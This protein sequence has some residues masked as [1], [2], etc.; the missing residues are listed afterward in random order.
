MKSSPY[1]VAVFA[2]VSA[3]FLSALT[4]SAQFQNIYGTGAKTT[5]F[6]K[7]IP[8]GA[9]FY[10][11]GAVGGLA[12]VSRINSAGVCQWTHS[13][14]ISSGWE[15]AVVVPGSG[16]LIMVG[17][18]GSRDRSI[19]G[20]LTRTG[21]EVCIT[22]LDEPGLEGLFRIDQNPGSNTYSVI[23]F[24][25]TPSTLRDVVIYNIS[26]NCVINSKKQ[27]FSTVDDDFYLN[28]EVMANG[29]ITVAG[30]QG[31][32]A[33]IF[34]MNSTGNFVAGVQGP[35]QFSY[36]DLARTGNGDLLAIAN[37]QT[38]SPP[39]VMRF[40]A[41]LLPVWEISVNGLFSLD[42]VLDGGNGEIYVMG[43]TNIGGTCCQPVV[44]KLDDSNGPPTTPVWTKYLTNLGNFASF[45][46]LT[47]GGQIATADA[48]FG[49]PNNFGP[50]DGVLLL[51]DR[52][53]NSDCTVDFDVTLT[54]EN[55][56]F[57]GP[58]PLELFAAEMPVKTP[59][60]GSMVALSQASVC[61]TDPCE[62]SF[63]VNYLDN[64]GHVEI[65]STSTGPQPIG[66][67]WCSGENTPNLDLQLPCGPY[68]YCVTITCADGSMSTVTQTIQVSE[69]IPPQAV[70][71]PGF[72]VILGPDCT[73]T[74]TPVMIDGGSTDNCRIE[75]MSVSPGV[76]TGC[77]NFPVTLSV[78]DWC[79]NVGACTTS[80]QTI[81][82]VP[83]V[84]MCPP[85]V[86]KNC[87]TDT[88]PNFTGMATA[89]DNC[90]SVPVITYADLTLG[91]LPCDGIIQRT[92]TATDSCGNEASCVQNIVVTDIDPPMINC[93][94]DLT[95]G[96]DPGQCFYTGTIPLPTAT[97]NCNPNP[98]VTCYLVT[99]SGLVPITTQTKFPKGDNTICC[100]ADDGCVDVG[101]LL[102]EA[103]CEANRWAEPG[104]EPGEGPENIL[105]TLDVQPGIPPQTLVQEGLIGGDCF[106]VSNVT[107][108]GEPSQLG[109]FTN[110]ISN[111]GFPSGVILATGPAILAIGP[112]DSDS[113]GIPMG[114]NNTPDPDLATLTTGTQYDIAVLEFD[115]IPT[116]GILSLNYV[117][118]SEEY[119]ELA[120]SAL[121]DVFGIFLSGPGIPGGKQ[122]IA[123]VPATTLPTGIGTVNHITNNGFYVNNQPAGSNNLCGQLPV[124]GPAVNELQYDGYTRKFTAVANVIP[125]Q[126]YHIKIAIADVGDGLNDSAVFLNGGSF[127]AGGI[128]SVAWVVNSDPNLQTI[129]EDCG[130]VEL[131]FDRLDQ[132]ITPLTVAFAVGGTATP[133]VDYVALP[134]SVTI[135]AG[136][137][138]LVLPVTILNEGV[139]EGDET[140]EITL[141]NPCSAV[142][143][144]ETLTIRDFLHTQA[145]CTFT[146]TVEDQ[147]PPMITCPPGVTVYAGLDS[148]GTCSTVLSDLI[149][150]FSDNCTMVMMDYV[151]SGATTAAG[152]NFIDSTA[153]AEGTSTV[154][155]TVTDMGGNTDTCTFMVTVVCLDEQAENCCLEWAGQFGGP[156]SDGGNVVTADAA[157]NVWIAG[158]F[159]GT[160]DFDPGPV[161]YNLTAQAGRDAFIVK[162]SPA[163]TFLWSLQ[164]KGSGFDA[165]NDLIL[166]PSGNLYI[167]GTFQGVADF[168]P[169]VNTYNLT[170]QGSADIFVL[171]LDPSGGFLWAFGI[172]STA[173]DVSSAIAL[174]AGGDLI[175]TGHFFGPL[176]FDPG[177]GVAG[178]VPIGSSD[179]FIANFSPSGAFNWV[180]QIGGPSLDASADL[181]TDLAGNILVTGSFTGTV[182][183]DPGPG[184]FNLSSG[185]VGSDDIFVTKFDGAGNFLWA[186]T[187]SRTSGPGSN[188]VNSIAVDGSG[189]VFTT[190]LLFGPTDFD[191]GPGTAVL[192]PVSPS[193]AD[194]FVS[195][196]SSTGAYEWAKR[197]GGSSGEGGESITTDSKGNVYTSGG[198]SGTFDFDPGP[199]VSVL[200]SPGGAST[201]IQKLT[202]AGDFIWAKPFGGLSSQS[203]GL[204]LFVAADESVYCSGT[205]SGSGDFDPGAKTYTLTAAGPYDAYLFKLSVCSKLDTCYC[206]AF[207]DMF[208]RGPQGAMSRPVLCGGPPLNIGCP[209]P[210]IGF[211]LTGS[212]MC[213]GDSCTSSADLDWSLYGPDNSL[214][215]SDTASAAPWF[216]FNLPSSAF[217]QSGVYTL[218]LSGHCGADSCPCNIQFMVEEGCMETCPCDIADLISDVNQGFATAYAAN[219]CRVCFTPLALSD[220]DEVEWFVD[221]P[222]GTAV[223]TSTGNQTFCH[224]FPTGGTYT[225][226]MTV[227]RKRADGSLCESS[228]KNQTVTVTCLTRTVCETSLFPNPDFDEGAVAGS[229]GMEGMSAGWTRA[230]GDPH[231]D[232]NGGKKKVR[233]A[234][235]FDNADV[236]S[237]QEAICLQKTTGTISLRHG[238]KVNGIRSTLN[239]QFFTG[240]DYTFGAC[241]SENCFQVARIEL[242]PSDTSEEFDVVIP[243]DISGWAPAELCGNGSGVMIRPAIFVTND[244][245]DEQ[246]V[247]TRSVIDLDYFCLD[248]ILVG[249]NGPGK[250]RSMRLYPNPSA[251]S[252][253]LELAQAASP[254][255]TIRIIGL[256][257]QVVNEQR[258]EI[259]RMQQRVEAGN[260]PAGLY[261]IQLSIEGRTVGVLKWVKQ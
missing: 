52:D 129:Y 195:K 10:V 77:G 182:D 133:G 236:L 249:V 247:D 23:G 132:A 194:I 58:Q 163:G 211:T 25:N 179:L 1:Y 176:D 131:V 237:T 22:F 168:D 108:R 24:H 127:D 232:V 43:R 238:I 9:D 251:G 137:D 224:T 186:N 240:D 122:N 188:H 8:D 46:S 218:I 119:C 174:G 17:A 48:L 175:L 92:W 255:T 63:T 256:T 201:F 71:L 187:F 20:E 97:D 258:V 143:P 184:V 109:A 80:V 3:L 243:Y 212:F 32:N 72:G 110:G 89:T 177:P 56:P 189:N 125:G 142:T 69:N 94:A 134:S 112:N 193:A 118:A 70:C 204:N 93:P 222:L 91:S 140:I 153:F 100:I 233:L 254:A 205:F 98:T 245:G 5:I 54:P 154:I 157:G 203:S 180:R 124:S 105:T 53:L 13:L 183:F 64:C 228:V 235:N 146:L 215:A 248:G 96:T 170:S 162:L 27:F 192:T 101:P 85:N 260:L 44:V 103:P 206:G 198:F 216:G 246:G 135:P 88:S 40:D 37:T 95:V 33:V 15:D 196:L 34:R 261:F 78:T 220:C 138:K 19:I 42:Q 213:A 104:G 147:E 123:V 39:R 209:A 210:G 120:T 257:G 6:Y 136:Q 185:L 83:P 191:P 242:P 49:H 149:P 128:A 81:E 230:W 90:T 181:V 161:V 84:I 26:P 208:I 253:T 199:G 114:G 197:M 150:G 75:S 41:D 241:S 61:G 82:I 65:V 113:K 259:G 111:I 50:Q 152:T 144:Q 106:D 165:I 116:T 225:V 47:P 139:L 86:Q 30:P 200:S 226:Y 2:M 67:Q 166:D 107:S 252:F 51:T 31:S 38:G 68:T 173:L 18:E 158:F 29:D 62:A 178:L 167:T 115:F 250:P 151:I 207:S 155:Y 35:A 156:L 223:G 66:Y 14:N 214:I 160:A 55:T 169:G 202:N 102:C 45:L 164:I 244:L 126:T 12:S 217:S 130:T 36:T 141:S 99:E 21:A 76:L 231:I 117:F 172:G 221:D 4:V 7:A 57:D 190:G 28:L 148:M 159:E 227:T 234:G 229:L 16:N 145:K 74:L 11:L 60:T 87:D 171:K 79:G 219:S 59:I 73:T 239:I 121:H